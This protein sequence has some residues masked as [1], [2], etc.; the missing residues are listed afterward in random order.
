MKN[1]RRDTCKLLIL[2]LAKLLSATP[3]FRKKGRLRVNLCA[4]HTDFENSVQYMKE[5]AY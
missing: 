2:Q 4:N 5:P 1:L 3:R